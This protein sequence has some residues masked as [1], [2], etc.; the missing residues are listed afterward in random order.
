MI[1]SVLPKGV[2]SRRSGCWMASLGRVTVLGISYQNFL[3]NSTIIRRPTREPLGLLP[4]HVRPSA[5]PRLPGTRGRRASAHT[6]P[7]PSGHTGQMGTLCGQR[8]L[9]GRDP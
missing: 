9:R 1:C 6:R 4:E 8:T 7:G 5:R 3:E 2:F